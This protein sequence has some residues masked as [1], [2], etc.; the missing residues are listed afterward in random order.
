MPDYTSI[1]RRSIAA[2]PDPSPEMRAVVYQRARAALARQLTAVDPPLSTREIETQ[3]QD[4][5]DAVARLEADYATDET[6]EPEEPEVPAAADAYRS[7]SP[8]DA[9]TVREEA[10]AAEEDQFEGA[11]PDFNGDAEDEDEGEEEFDDEE[12]SSR[13]PLIVGGLV[14]LLV[15]VGIG[16]YLYA[17]RDRIARLL[18]FS[19][20]DQEMAAAPP[21]APINVVPPAEPA[22]AVDPN[23]LPDRLTNGAEPPPAEAPPA[24]VAAA[25]PEI[26]LQL[27]ADEEEPIPPL[28]EVPPATP[29][30]VAG[31]APPRPLLTRPRPRRL[32][33]RPRPPAV[34][35]PEQQTAA[36][37][38]P[39][40]SI[41]AQR[42]IFYFKGTEGSP[43]RQ[44]DGNATWAQITRDGAPAIQATLRF[45]DQ[46]VTTTLT[47]YKNNDAS[48]P[49]SHLVEVQF[50]GDLGSSPVQRVPALVLKPTEQARGE[51]LTGAAVPVTSELFWL[52]LSDDQERV[53]RNL[54]LLREGSWFD[55]PILFDDGA[56][57][58]LT[59]EKGI[60]GDRVFETVMSGWI[61]S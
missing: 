25:E 29:P 49:A 20:E 47:I 23:K 51:P 41:V 12:R 28:V 30:E 17:E 5:E 21:P 42:A 38:Q 8:A 46:E 58:L 43:A 16:A 24:D 45:S 13:L 6:S 19:S 37:E 15:I 56:Q 14:L 60:P 9:E 54:Q 44:V 33:K 61:P 10:R 27:P 53:T 22:P 18:D 3:H 1:L 50:S 11:S 57:G 40:Q 26:P 52:A 7:T 59:F 4:L 35:P 31:E 2:L 55:L 39:G 36:L 32:P 34:V 48:L